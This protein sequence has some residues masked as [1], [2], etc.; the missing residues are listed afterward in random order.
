LIFFKNSGVD[1]LKRFDNY[2][3]FCQNLTY[4]NTWSTGFSVWRNDFLEFENQNFDKMF[5]HVTLLNL[6]SHNKY[7]IINDHQYFINQEVKGKGGYNLF[8]TFGVDYLA[9]MH[10]AFINK[11]ITDITYSKIKKELFNKFL[12]AW[13]FNTKINKN[14]YTFDLSDIKKSIGVNYGIFGYTKLVMFSY[15]LLLKKI[16]YKILRIFKY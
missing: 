7:F 8:K 6:L 1:G 15:I 10:N 4:W 14:D 9:L 3:D 5:P 16:F 11:V 2:N 12:V 13:Y